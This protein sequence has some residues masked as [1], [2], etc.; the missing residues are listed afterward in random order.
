MEIRKFRKLLWQYQRGKLNESDA[1]LVDDWYDSFGYS[2]DIPPLQDAARAAAIRQQLQENL[3][4]HVHRRRG[5]SVV[6]LFRRY[7]AVLLLLLGTAVLFYLFSQQRGRL[8]RQTAAQMD[9]IITLTGQL[10]KITLPDSSVLSLNAGSTVRYSPAG[11]HKER[12]VYLDAGEAFFTVVPHADLPFVVHS[13]CL[14]TTVLGTA[15]NVSAYPELDYAAV[16]VQEGRVSVQTPQG[17]EGNILAVGEGLVY[18]K[19]TGKVER[20]RQL[21]DETAGWM[22][23]TTFLQD[24]SF[25]ELA[26][27]FHNQFGIRLRSASP[28]VQK[29]HY[30]I[31]VSRQQQPE[32]LVKLICSIHNKQYRRENNEITIY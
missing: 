31:Q 29:G 27:V 4:K 28:A 5:A 19:I 26:L 1:R 13:P 14:T 12:A 20:K 30:T 21:P 24:A 7:A 17:K 8:S 25:L 6:P 9:T 23:G 22:K 2:E 18:N 15:F 16:S 11:F 32:A 10:K 3:Q